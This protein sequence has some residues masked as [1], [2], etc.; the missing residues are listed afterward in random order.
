MYLYRASVY[1]A[2]A[3]SQEKRHLRNAFAKYRCVEA[4]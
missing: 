1:I 2:A 4:G 3:C